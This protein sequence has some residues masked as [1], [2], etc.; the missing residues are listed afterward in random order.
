MSRLPIASSSVPPPPPHWHCARATGALTVA[1]GGRP[2]AALAGLL[3]LKPRR[4][5]R[6]AGW[7]S[8]LAG[9]SGPGPRPARHHADATAV[10]VA[11]LGALFRVPGSMP[12]GGP[13]AAPS[14]SPTDGAWSC[15]HYEQMCS[16][17]WMIA[18]IAQKSE[19]RQRA[20]PRA[21]ARGR[22]TRKL[23]TH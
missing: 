23:E 22:H 4:P 8:L 13:L 15:R 7:G 20:I 5:L 14:H 16:L 3:V 1:C 6:V 19:R 9:A 18:W 10:P 12:A 11:A 21:R 2:P 17:G